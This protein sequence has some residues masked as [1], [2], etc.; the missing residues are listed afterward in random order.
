MIKQSIAA[1]RGLA[2]IEE[3]FAGLCDL[4]NASSIL[5]WDQEVVMPPG[6]AK[7]R[8]RSLATLAAVTFEKTSDPRL[9]DLVRDLRDR[10]AQ[11]T[12]R[13]NRMVDL[14]WRRIREVTSI[15]K[16]LAIEAALAKSEALEAWKK[17]RAAD[18][19]P[20]FAP[21][22]ERMLAI[23]KRK[24]SA[25]SEGRDPYD[26]AIDHYEPGGTTAT[27]D[28][29]LDELEALTVDLLERVRSSRV[30]LDESPVKGA[31]DVEQQRAFVAEV[32]QAMGIEM[33]RARLDVSTHPFCGGV[34]PDDVRMTGRFDGRD[35]RPGLYGAIHEA[36][37]GLYEQGLDPRRARSVLGGAVSMAIHESQSRLW[38]NLIGRS[39]PFWK[40]W[41]GPLRKRFQKTLVGVR[42]VDMWRATNTIRPSLIRVEADEL[43]YNLHITLR[44]RIERELFAG[45]LAVR[46][47]PERWNTAMREAL[48]LSPKDNAHGCLQDIHWAMGAFGYFPTYSLGNLYACQFLE[49]ARSALPELD[50]Q[51]E[52]GDLAPLASWL[53]TNIHRHDRIYTADQLVKK[54]TKR[55]LSVEPFRRY[56]T[57]KIE[58]LYG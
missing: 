26:C 24:A 57:S 18:D 6:G 33:S 13:Q 54:V 2:E 47:L 39:K 10:S 25:L 32:I 3:H 46:D 53:H 45:S 35:L 41:I 58:A 23:A 15:P 48:G 37:H 27:F 36:G 20:A 52:N 1:Q 40:H 19:F 21:S 28:P 42:A 30:K 31:F 16:E 56:A 9:L 34:G 22:L 55:A 38:E 4:D 44:Y 12:S 14:A 5:G 29:L 7:L 50:S 49:A 8:A 43:T 11:L 17:A 51:V